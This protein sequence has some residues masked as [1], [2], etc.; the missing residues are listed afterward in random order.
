[1]AGGYIAG[2][3]DLEM[4]GEYTFVTAERQNEPTRRIQ[5]KLVE[6]GGRTVFSV[7]PRLRPGALA[8][9]EPMTSLRQ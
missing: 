7:P 1:M 6:T 9:A 3:S 8:G 2:H 4:R 5:E